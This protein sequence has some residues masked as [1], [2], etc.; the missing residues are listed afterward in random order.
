MKYGRNKLITERKYQCYS[1]GNGGWFGGG[2]CEHTASTL[3]DSGRPSDCES[4]AACADGMVVADVEGCGGKCKNGK[5]CVN[6]RCQTTTRGIKGNGVKTYGKK[7]RQAKE[8]SKHITMKE[9]ELIRT[10]EK[11][12]NEQMLTTPTN[13]MVGGEQSAGM[14]DLTNHLTEEILMEYCE[15]SHRSGCPRACGTDKPVLKALHSWCK[16][17]MGQRI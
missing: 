10:I 2:K 11:I 17:G 12:V 7:T 6:G 16:T 9:S 4:A 3:S 5:T 14:G 13:T 8:A 15:H 1:K